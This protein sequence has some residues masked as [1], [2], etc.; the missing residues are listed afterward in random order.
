M[1]SHNEKKLKRFHIGKVYR[2]DQPVMT[3]GRF[4]EFYQCDLD[5]AGKTDTMMAEAEILQTMVEVLNNFN[6]KR[7]NLDFKIKVS[8]RLLLEAIVECA[9]CQ[10]IKFKAICSS[11][12]KLDKESWESVRKELEQVKGVTPQQ[13]DV[14]EKIV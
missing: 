12:D 8:H 9:G 3:K 13:C 2:R 1:A 4:R 11:I 6:F 10:P 14:L 5:I 7:F